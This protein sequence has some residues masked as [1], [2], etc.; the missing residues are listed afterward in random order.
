[1]AS[2]ADMLRKIAAQLREKSEQLTQNKTVKT[3]QVIQAAT[4]LELLRR[5]V[6]FDGV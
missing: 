1:M 6:Q 5:K 4:A 3:A 2:E